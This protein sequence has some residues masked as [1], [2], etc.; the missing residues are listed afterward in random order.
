FSYNALGRHDVKTGGEFTNHVFDFQWCSYCKGNL[1]A[2]LL[3]APS[4]DALYAMLP[5]SNDASTWNPLPLSSSSIRYRQSV[6]HFQLENDAQHQSNLAA[7][8]LI[9]EALYDGRVDFA[10]NP[11]NG[12]RPTIDQARARLCSTALTPTCIRREIS[13]EIPSP[14][15]KLTYSHQTSAGV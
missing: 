5:V 1:D 12:P 8:T 6:A 7:Q 4:A 3:A 14:N 10:V 2:T 11:F 13:S 15:H 9:P